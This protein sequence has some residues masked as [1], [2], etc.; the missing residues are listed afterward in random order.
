[1]K[2]VNLNINGCLPQVRD[3]RDGVDGKSAYQ[4]WLDLGNKGTE[5]DFIKSLKGADGIIGKDGAEGPKGEKGDKGDKGDTGEQGPIGPQGLQGEVGPQGPQGEKGEQGL[6]GEK[7]EKGDTGPVGPQGPAGR[8]GEG[9]DFCTAFDALPE[10]A[11]KKGTTIIA[12]QDGACVRLTALDSIFQEIGV[13]IT[14]DKTNGLVSDNYKVVVTVSNTGEGKNELTNLNIVGPANTVEY[15]IKEVSFTKSEA[16]EVEQID[17]FTY[18]IRGLKKGGT[19]KVKF[20]V[21]PKV[22]GTFQFTAAVNPN[23]ALDKDLGNNN[24]TIILRSDTA[25]KA[26][27]GENC[28][29]ITLKDKTTNAVLTQIV[30]T[31]NSNNNAFVNSDYRIIPTLSYVNIYSTRNTLNGVVLV[32]DIDITAVCVAKKPEE[33]A[34]TFGIGTLT[35]TIYSELPQRIATGVGDISGLNPDEVHAITTNS[36]SVSGKEIT[37]TEDVTAMLLLVRPRGAN[38]YWQ[39]YMLFASTPPKLEKISVTDLAGGSISSARLPKV[40]RDTLSKANIVGVGLQDITSIRNGYV[41]KQIITVNQG[42][43]ATATLDFGKLTKFYSSGLVEITANNLTVSANATPSD[44]IRST[45]L[46]VI[47]EE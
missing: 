29:A 23:S 13:G 16:D 31:I 15:E 36:L 8:D 4:Q 30:P 7:G 34:D 42:T 26:I 43:A 22:K 18:N 41:E 38:C 20:T 2:T 35:G 44:S 45:Y 27:T 46:D 17:N 12:K 33:L 39:A 19:V 21:V 11:W 25:S 3:G 10:V 47:I 24:A 9:A 28:Q 5:A 14:A 40:Q 6:K 37:I 32:G 1:M